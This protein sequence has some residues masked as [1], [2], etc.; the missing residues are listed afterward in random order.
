MTSRF[1]TSLTPLTPSQPGPISRP[2]SGLDV[3]Y[4]SNLVVMLIVFLH[5]LDQGWAGTLKGNTRRPVGRS[6]PGAPARAELARYARTAATRVAEGV[7]TDAGSQT[8]LRPTWLGPLTRL[9]E[10]RKTLRD[11]TAKSRIS[12]RQRGRRRVRLR[13]SARRP[14]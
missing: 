1:G 10:R 14:M 9:R 5:L 3:A 13:S 7:P 4:A 2:S 11:T 8:S 6:L 12:Q